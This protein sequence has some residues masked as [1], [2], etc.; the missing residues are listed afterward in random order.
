MQSSSVHPSLSFT[1]KCE[2]K[3]WDFINVMMFTTSSR[4]LS[5][6]GII[7]HS[8]FV[9]VMITMTTGVQ[10]S[11]PSWLILR[12]R[13]LHPLLLLH[14]ALSGQ[15]SEHYKNVNNVFMCWPHRL[16]ERVSGMSNGLLP[17]LGEPGLLSMLGEPMLQDQWRFIN[18]PHVQNLYRVQLMITTTRN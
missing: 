7:I 18:Y 15:M 12:H 8:Q 5:G 4:T 13:Q 16:T 10:C 14:Y 17:T 6:T 1:L 3:G 9:T 2:L 11:P